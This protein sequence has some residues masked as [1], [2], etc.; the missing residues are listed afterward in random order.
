MRAG[1]GRC[2]SVTEAITPLC[3]I[4]ATSPRHFSHAEEFGHTKIESA[5][6]YL[7]I[8]VDDALAIAEQTQSAQRADI[9]RTCRIGRLVLLASHADDVSPR[10]F[11]GANPRPPQ[12]LNDAAACKKYRAGGEPAHTSSAL[13]TAWSG[14]RITK[15]QY[16][17][18]RL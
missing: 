18:T 4:F 5:V 14:K 11:L 6:R 13:Q 1:F 15:V 2:R 16:G 7:G 3:E 9:K 12:S 10:V 8:E 17:G